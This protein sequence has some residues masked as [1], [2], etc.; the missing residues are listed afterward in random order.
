MKIPK[1]DVDYIIWQN[2]AF[3][4]YVPARTCFYKEF[5]P[6]AAFLSQQCLEQLMKATLKWLDPSFEPKSLNHNLR[7]MSQM[8]REKVPSQGD[9]MVPEYICKYQSLTRYPDPNGKGYLVPPT[10]IAEVD[11]LFA[12]LVEMVPCKFNSQLSLTLR[13]K[14]SHKN[15]YVDLEQNNEQMDRL[16]KHVLGPRAKPYS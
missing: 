4:F 7:K 8:I 3:W 13:E 10:L 11:C 14:P 2:R 5:H 15:W 16:R 1:R 12:D 6:P 9:F